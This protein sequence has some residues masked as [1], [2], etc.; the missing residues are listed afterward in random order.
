MIFSR[1]IIV[2][3]GPAGSSCGWKLHQNGIECLILDKKE[4]PREKLCAGWITP[5]VIDDLKINVDDYPNNLT[6]FDRFHIHIYNR[7]LNLKV[8]QYSIRR[9]EFDNWLLKRSGIPVRTHQVKNIRKDGDIYIIDNDY[10]CEYLVGA[11]GTHCPVRKTFFKHNSP[12]SKEYVIATLEEEFSHDYND[13]NCHLWFFQNSLPGYSWYVPKK[14]GYLNIGIGGFLEKLKRNNDSIKNQWRLFTREL[15]RLSLVRNHHFNAKGAIYYIRSRVDSVQT[16]KRYLI[17][18]AAGLATK[19][20]GE[21]IGPAIKSGILA[22]D[23]I[24]NGK[25]FS[26]RSLKKYSFPRYQTFFRVMFTYFFNYNQNED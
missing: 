5:Q 9:S 18:D 2:G 17:G 14:D 15:E 1:V 20:M 8:H 10:S 16:G 12:R 19:D 26:L 11:G 6:T 22:A 13:R 25:N 4:F 21:G 24:S 3:G 23:A 7:V